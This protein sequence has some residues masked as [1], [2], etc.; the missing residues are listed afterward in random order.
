MACVEA[1]ALREDRSSEMVVADE[2][3]Q[4]K[5]KNQVMTGGAGRALTSPALPGKVLA[6]LALP[7]KV[8]AARRRIWWGVARLLPWTEV[9][10]MLV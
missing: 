6:S 10:A 4:Q 1:S 2:D 7:G 8:L 9:S 3:H 5:V